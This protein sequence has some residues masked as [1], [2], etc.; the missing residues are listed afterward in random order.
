MDPQANL[1]QLLLPEATRST[2]YDLLEGRVDVDS[3]VE[4]VR[5]NLDIHLL[6]GCGDVQYYGVDVDAD[7]RVLRDILCSADLSEVDVVL[8]DT[9]PTFCEVSLASFAASDSVLVVT[10]AEAPSVAGIDML[11]ANVCRV[12]EMS[13]P[14]LGLQGIVVNKVDGRRRLPRRVCKDLKKRYGGTVFDT[15]I[16]NNT[17]VPSAAQRGCFVRE[18]PWNGKVPSQFSDLTDELIKRM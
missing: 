8:I 2:V 9:P 14:H 10:E 11:L 12:R 5:P 1:T 6:P 17:A 18:V 15:F 3:V 13:N 7:E 16:G 4:R